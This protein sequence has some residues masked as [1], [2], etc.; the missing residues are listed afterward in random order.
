M[1]ETINK[2]IRI[3][4][5]LIQELGRE[6]EAE[7]LAQEMGMTVEKVREIMKISQE[8]VSLEKADR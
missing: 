7:E 2:L 6:P 5:Q 3:Q 4:R 1:V 8:P